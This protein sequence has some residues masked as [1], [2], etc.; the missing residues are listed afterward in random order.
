MAGPTEVAPEKKSTIFP[1]MIATV[2]AVAVAIAIVM[3]VGYYLA[4]SGRLASWLG[5]PLPAPPPIQVVAP[6]I[7]SLVLDP[8]IVNVAGGGGKSYLRIGITLR[9]FDAE[10]KKD[11]KAKGE[12]AKDAKGGGDAEAAVRDTALDVLGRQTAEGLLSPEGK[13]NLKTELKEA[14]AKHN[15]DQRVAD[16][17]FTEFLVQR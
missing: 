15:A 12:T 9:I 7:H 8:L 10:L 11:E 2:T 1:L 14:I 13:D 5:K 17:Y 6:P 3:G 4:K 16:V